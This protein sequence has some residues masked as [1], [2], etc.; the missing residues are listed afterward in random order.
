MCIIGLPFEHTCMRVAKAVQS[1]PIMPHYVNVASGSF[2]T[3]INGTVEVVGV[4]W[5]FVVMLWVCLALCKRNEVRIAMCQ[6]CCKH[7]HKKY[8]S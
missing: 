5:L 4:K 8:D 3:G 6:M 2:Y 1:E 7:S